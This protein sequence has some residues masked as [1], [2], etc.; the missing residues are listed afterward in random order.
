MLGSDGSGG[1]ADGKCEGDAVSPVEKYGSL[2]KHEAV[3]AWLSNVALNTKSGQCS[4]FLNFIFC[5]EVYFA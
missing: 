1:E 2:D 5:M 4:I 3:R